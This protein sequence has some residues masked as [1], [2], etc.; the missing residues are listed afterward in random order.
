MTCDHCGM[1]NPENAKFCKHCGKKL[2]E[3]ATEKSPMQATKDIGKS[4]VMKG[5]PKSS[6]ATNPNSEMTMDATDIPEDTASQ[7]LE[8]DNNEKETSDKQSKVPQNDFKLSEEI[9]IFLES[10]P[11]PKNDT[12]CPFCHSRNCHPIQKSST[13]VSKSGYSLSNGCCGM[14]LL[15]PFGVI[16]GLCGTSTKVDVKNESWWT[17]MD[18]GKEHISQKSAIEKCEAVIASSYVSALIGG[19]LLSFAIWS[20]G[21]TFIT[22]ILLCV[23]FGMTIGPWYGIIDVLK[24]E[25]GYSIFEILPPEKKKNYLCQFIGCISLLLLIGLLFMP[26]L[27]SLA[28]E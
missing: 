19:V 17:C 28:G 1:N 12:E 6:G 8:S 3:A 16:C 25:L 18:C 24:G 15:G 14:C 27:E 7:H 23:A 26:L 22:L 10:D 21:L 13:T 20:L 4:Q 11:I 2:I 9:R 5:H